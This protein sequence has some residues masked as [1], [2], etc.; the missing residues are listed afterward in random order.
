MLSTDGG[1]GGYLLGKP[2]QRHLDVVHAF[3]RHLVVICTD[4]AVE[5]DVSGLDRTLPYAINLGDES[6]RGR[7]GGG[8]R[9]GGGKATL[10]P[11]IMMGIHP[12]QREMSAYLKQKIKIGAN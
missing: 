3:G 11:H 4:F 8:G 9:A 10:L 1:G 2:Q 5:I 7:V 6:V 12:T